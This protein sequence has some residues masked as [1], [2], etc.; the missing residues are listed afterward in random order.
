M[1]RHEAVL[2]CAWG[3]KQELTDKEYEDIIT[4]KAEMNPKCGHSKWTAKIEA[5]H[6]LDTT[7]W[8]HCSGKAI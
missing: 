3:C 4:D 2:T 1:S 5:K 6:Y 8:K 7:G